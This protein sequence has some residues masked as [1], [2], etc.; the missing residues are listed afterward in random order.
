MRRWLLKIGLWGATAGCLDGACFV[1]GTRVATPRGPRPIEDLKV[2]DEVWSWSFADG[3]PVRGRVLATLT[4]T[5]PEVLRLR[6]GELALPGVSP[7]HPIWS[8]SAR[9]W[10]AAGELAVGAS[11]LGWLGAGDPK[12][13]ALTERVSAGGPAEVFNLTVDGAHCYFAEGLLVHNKE[14]AT[15]PEDADEDGYDYVVDCDDD[16]PD[17]HPDAVEDCTNQVDDDCDDDVDTDDT[18]CPV[19]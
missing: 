6:A 10:R 8:A 18:D 4:R 17:V 12:E 1:R 7:D 15:T 19:A 3:G 13:V 11:L 16:D 5:V 14:P 2:G 9:G